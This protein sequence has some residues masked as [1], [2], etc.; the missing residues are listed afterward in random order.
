MIFREGRVIR[1]FDVGVRDR[2]MGPPRP[3]EEACSFIMIDTIDVVVCS[4]VC[5]AS[6]GAFAIYDN[7]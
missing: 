4:N 6:V 5:S 2:L 7:R 1:G 3:S